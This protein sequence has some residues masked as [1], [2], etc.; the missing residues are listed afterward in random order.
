MPVTAFL[1]LRWAEDEDASSWQGYAIMGGMAMANVMAV[2]LKEV[3]ARWTPI[4]P[5]P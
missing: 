2:L 4:A 1:M 3:F 5:N